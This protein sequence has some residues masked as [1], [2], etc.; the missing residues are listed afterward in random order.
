MN[1]GTH[2]FLII[3]TAKF[4]VVAWNGFDRLRFRPLLVSLMEA[5]VNIFINV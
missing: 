5:K 1:I 4:L 2:H 3:D